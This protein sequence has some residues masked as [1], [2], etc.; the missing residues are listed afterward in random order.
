MSSRYRTGGREPILLDLVQV[1]R[2]VG[3][4]VSAIEFLLVQRSFPE[5]TKADGKVLF[6]SDE[7]EAWV[8]K[9]WLARGAPNNLVS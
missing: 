7:I 4:P 1:S 2:R 5:P 6:H 3:L 9:R 8:G